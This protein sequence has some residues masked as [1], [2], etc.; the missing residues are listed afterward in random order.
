MKTANYVCVLVAFP[1]LTL[2]Q[3]CADIKD[4]RE[5]LACYDAM[6]KPAA[7]QPAAPVQESLPEASSAPPPRPE[8][9]PVREVR[10][11]PDSAENFGLKERP[12]DRQLSVTAKIEKLEKAGSVDYLYLDNGQVWRETGGDSGV[13][14]KKGKMVTITEGAL[15]SYDLLM[16]GRNRKAK[17][18]R[19][20]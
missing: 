14:F 12:E 5:R 9:E 4:D 16:E 11:P 6:N 13:R 8:P 3:D 19:V 1:G 7:T 2:A 20:R 18:R 15:G 17:V 10:S